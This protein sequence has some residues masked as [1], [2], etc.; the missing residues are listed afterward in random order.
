MGSLGVNVRLFEKENKM[1]Q[2]IIR[3]TEDELIHD[4][5]FILWCL[6]PTQELNEFYQDYLKL[7]PEDEAL[8]LSARN[9]VRKLRLST[10]GTAMTSIEHDVLKNRIQ[11]GIA[12]R[13]KRQLF[14]RISY[15]AAACILLLI[16]VNL[17]QQA[18][19]SENEME[20]MPLTAESLQL[21]QQQTEV[22]LQLANEQT[23][24]VPNNTE[25]RVDAK[26]QIQIEN[27]A[28]HS[29]AQ[30]TPSVAV[31]QENTLRV[32]R[33]RRS[34]LILPDSS[35][36]WVNA[37]TILRFPQQFQADNRTIH[38]NGEIY[39]EVKKDPTRPFFVK[40]SQMDIR[41]LGTSFCVTAYQ[42]EEAQ[43]VVLKEGLVAVNDRNG[44]EQKITPDE[45]LVLSQ[46]QMTVKEVDPYNYISWIDGILQFKERNLGQILDQL[47][48]YYRI[49]F[50]CPEELESFKYSGKLV[51]FDDIHQVLNTLKTSLPISYQE[52]D[53]VIDIYP[54]QE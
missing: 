41:V 14:L 17:F 23:M 2:N 54:T 46:D 21:D 18:G 28:I 30:A 31:S 49:T 36:V 38:V 47:S 33:G 9:K 45:M 34:F 52:K 3:K 24:Q 8:L 32:P 48:R 12:K 7:Y 42:D 35:Q 27:K 44:T 1:R 29:I 25:I 22:E 40:T 43:S 20:T 10:R 39:L 16:L 37:G 51:L 53:E 13:Q 5:T 11:Q 26:G 6:F 15:L 50:N 4:K 19:I